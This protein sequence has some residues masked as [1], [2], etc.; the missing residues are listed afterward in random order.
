LKRQ[1]K[2]L[3]AGVFLKRDDMLNKYEKLRLESMKK[4]LKEALKMTAVTADVSQQSVPMW[5]LLTCPSSRCPCGP[6]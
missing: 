4:R 2:D 3:K 1:E 5:Y 6:C